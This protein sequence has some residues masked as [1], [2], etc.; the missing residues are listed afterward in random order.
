[1]TS[2]YTLERNRLALAIGT[3]LAV[4]AAQAGEDANIVVTTTEDAPVGTIT[5]ECTLRDAVASAQ[6]Q[7]AIGGCD[8]GQDIINIIGFDEALSHSVITLSE[9]Q[10]GIDDPE[11]LGISG[12]VPGDPD[13]ITIDGNHESRLFRIHGGT[14]VGL[15]YLTLTG[16]QT[17]TGSGEMY[18][19]AG[20]AIRATNTDLFIEDVVLTNNRTDAFPAPGGALDA[21]GVELE[22]HDSVFS[23]NSTLDDNSWGGAM[24][25]THSDVTIRNSV[26]EN[27]STNGAFSR[28]GAMRVHH[29][30]LEVTRSTFKHNATL[31]EGSK[32]GA[33]HA[34]S[35]PVT[36][37]ESTIESNSTEQSP[38]GGLY[39]SHD[40]ITLTNST[41]S[42]NTAGGNG[43][44]GGGIHSHRSDLVL[45][46]STISGNSATSDGGGI[47]FNE[48]DVED[49]TFGIMYSTVAF[50]SSDQGG[51]DGIHH[52]GDYSFNLRTSL[53]VQ[54][55]PG[56]IGCNRE[57]DKYLY[58]L[59]T[60]ATCAGS[61][62]D[63]SDIALAPLARNG[64]STP[65]HAIS[66]N[67]VAVDAGAQ[68][69][70]QYGVLHDQRDFPRPGLGT[71]DCDAG[72][73][74]AQPDEAIF[75]DAFYEG[76]MR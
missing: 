27:N 34:S 17:A 57:P 37:T 67:S 3:V 15:K 14:Q 29:G 6:D 50:N 61:A 20:G 66:T 28:G 74:E 7:A 31:G 68:C 70:T 8:S 2:K 69:H 32:G 58:S 62:S 53:V 43:S 46:Q 44:T 55:E 51:T 64:G 48:G 39:V 47:Y 52:A 22:I 9:G 56:S 11:T 38:G 60:D 49:H 59:S 5:D 26:I 10:I 41:V 18:D 40:E 19:N 73:F 45:E 72:A 54:D 23:N 1:M 16:G 75:N 13:G 36:L 63:A 30:S 4:G 24:E 71:S 33:I 76:P 42:G 12:P 35:L 21:D 25:L 65:T